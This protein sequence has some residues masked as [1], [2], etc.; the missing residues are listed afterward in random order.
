MAGIL[1]GLAALASACGSDSS[2]TIS[3]TATGTAEPVATPEVRAP[4]D[5]F[6]SVHFADDQTGWVAGYSAADGGGVILATTDG[7]ATW[8]RQLSAEGSINAVKFT[9]ALNGVA[10]L[11]EYAGRVPISTTIV[12]TV[13]GGQTWSRAPDGTEFDDPCRDAIGN[14]W[15]IEQDGVVRRTDDGGRTWQDSFT[16]PDNLRRLNGVQIECLGDDVV[17]IALHGEVA[18]SNMTYA[19]YRT[20]DGGETWRPALQH[21]VPEL[22]VPDSG[23]QPGP[24][25][26]VDRSVAFFIN[27]CSACGMYQARIWRTTDGGASWD[28]PVEIPDLRFANDI[29]FLDSERGWAVG[30]SYDQETLD[31]DGPAVILAT[32][33]GGKTWTQQYP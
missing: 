1:A 20:L 7:G 5:T 13:D 29:Q 21:Q 19:V 3:P 9:D 32:T 22:D 28:T 8:Q 30:P 33:D 18:S 11:V 23:S 16:P 10:A 26:I 25:R 15:T 6:T 27:H 31:Y 12:Q 17:W 14:G 4:S 24:I 2:S